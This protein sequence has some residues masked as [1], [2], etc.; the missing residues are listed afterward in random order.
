MFRRRLPQTYWQKA[1][2]FLWPREGWIRATLYLWRRT[3]RLSG[4]P[5]SIA[6]G[7]AIGAFVS[8]NPILGTHILWA[9]FIIY[10]I[11]GNFLAA[12]LGTWMGNPLSFPFIW[13]AT[14]NLGHLILG[15]SGDV[16][17]LPKLSLGLLIDAPIGTL[18]PLI[19]PMLLGWIPVGLVLGALVYYPSYW[20]IET[21]Q[22]RR[23][24]RLD[25][26]RNAAAKK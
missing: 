11:G 15:T 25:R 13:L 26:K 22:V 1:R 21:Y 19:G 23:R 12:V 14:F 20:S 4:T 3:I 16:Q 18:L 7:L 10:F 2:Q 5:H 9:A 8:A 24:A 17:K 6:L